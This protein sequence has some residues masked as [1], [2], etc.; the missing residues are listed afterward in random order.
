M[1]IA[2][3]ELVSAGRSAVAHEVPGG[4]GAL[5]GAYKL[6]Y[7]L[8]CAV[9]EL[10]LAL[11]AAERAVNAAERAEDELL[12]GI[13]RRSMARAL[14]RQGWLDE[15]GVV[16]SDAADAILPDDAS[17]RDR[18]RCGGRCSS[19]RLSWLAGPATRLPLKVY[20]AMRG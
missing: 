9:G 11:I 10:D 7:S 18:W 20:C 12:V 19:G 2:L 5:S 13:A 8:A 1:A 3:P 17:S 6:T 15:A 4:W 16:C 14:M